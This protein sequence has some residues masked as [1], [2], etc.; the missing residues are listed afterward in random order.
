MKSF[1]FL[2]LL[3][4]KFSQLFIIVCCSWSIV[5]VVLCESDI[6][7]IET[8]KK[9][10]KKWCTKL[11]LLPSIALTFIFVVTLFLCVFKAS[12]MVRMHVVAVDHIG[13]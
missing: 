10:K 6:A 8:F 4:Q 11:S 2:D 7:S 3:L 12:R 1:M 5:E 9:E 13:Q